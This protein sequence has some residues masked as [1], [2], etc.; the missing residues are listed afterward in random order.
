MKSHGEA[1]RLHSTSDIFLKFVSLFA[2]SLNVLC[3]NLHCALHSLSRKCSVN[4]TAVCRG[5]GPT[6]GWSPRAAVWGRLVASLGTPG[7]PATT[8]GGQASGPNA[9]R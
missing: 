9:R 8:S 2:D 3:S 5:R 7:S 6:M 4:S 1:S